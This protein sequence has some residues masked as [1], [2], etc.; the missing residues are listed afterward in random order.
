MICGYL[1][2]R[3]FED[4]IRLFEEISCRNVISKTSM[5][6]G[7]YSNE[8]TNEKVVVFSYFVSSA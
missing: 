5:I 3:R 6:V 4:A 7:L 2:N 8:R 1:Y